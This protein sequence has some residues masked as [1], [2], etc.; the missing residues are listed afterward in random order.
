MKRTAQPRP[1][2][3]GGRDRDAQ[4]GAQ[5]AASRA[6]AFDDDDTERLQH[7]L[8]LAGPVDIGPPL[9]GR[10]PVELLDPLIVQV[11]VQPG[12]EAGLERGAFRRRGLGKPVR[13]PFLGQIVQVQLL[14]VHLLRVRCVAGRLGARLLLQDRAIA[15]D[16][17][18]AQTPVVPEDVAV[19]VRQAVVIGLPPGAPEC[20]NENETPGCRI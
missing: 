7:L 4:L 8:I 1:H 6:V 10:R 9:G 15:I 20:V 3:V 18:L 14:Q 17:R 12:I 2:L 5:V 13:P 16:D 11:L 19:E